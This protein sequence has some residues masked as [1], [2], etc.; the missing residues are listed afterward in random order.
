M[1]KY[2]DYYSPAQFEVPKTMQAL[3][4]AGPGFENLHVTEVP[5]PEVGPNQLLGRVDAACA[6]FRVALTLQA[7]PVWA[8]RGNPY[9][10][11][12]NTL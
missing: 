1:S 4:A 5:V 7:D 9:M 2:E 12:S 3:I 11:D 6:P 8:L 10:R